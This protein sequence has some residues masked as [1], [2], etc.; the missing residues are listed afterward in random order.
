[1][2]DLAAATDPLPTTPPTGSAQA[3]E[4]QPLPSRYGASPVPSSAADEVSDWTEGSTVEDVGKGSPGVSELT[5]LASKY[6]AEEKSVGGWK[7]SAVVD[8]RPAVTS[9]SQSK[10]G[11]TSA[12]PGTVGGDEEDDLLDDSAVL[13]TQLPT[14]STQT[15]PK[16]SVVLWG[17]SLTSKS[18]VCSVVCVVLC[19]QLDFLHGAGVAVTGRSPSSAAVRLSDRGGRRETDF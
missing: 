10:W 4:S 12:P 6:K 19:V 1:M 15:Q 11:E 18:C 5:A 17:L 13:N 14:T 7:K 16:L 8:V 2:T 9:A 3:W